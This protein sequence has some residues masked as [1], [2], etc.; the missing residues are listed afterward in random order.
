ME[1][2]RDADALLSVMYKEY[3]L[4][5]KNGTP[6]LQAKIFG[7]AAYL[8][9][10]LAPKLSVEDVAETCRELGRAEFLSNNYADDTVSIC[11]LTDKAIIHMEN[12]FKNGL[13]EVLSYLEKIKSILFF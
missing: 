8:Q 13:D 1:L 11:Q 9:E 12:R 10:T 2:T 7:G 6:K 3:L 5:K 4:R